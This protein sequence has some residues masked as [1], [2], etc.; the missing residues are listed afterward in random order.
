M[1]EKLIELLSRKVEIL[2]DG[3][4]SNTCLGVD[5]E[6]ELKELDKEIE[7]LKYSI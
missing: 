7:R 3:I 5:Y 1:K 4:C 2:E 6:N